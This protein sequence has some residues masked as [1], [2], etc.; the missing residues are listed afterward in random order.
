ML[1]KSFILIFLMVLGISAKVSW[2]GNDD[3]TY[4]LGLRYPKSYDAKIDQN[5]PDIHF[6]EYKVRLSFPSKEVVQFYDDKLKAIGWVP[7]VEPNYPKFCDRT[8]DHFIDGT[9]K[10]TPIVHQLCAQWVTKD[11]NRMVGLVIR[12]HSTYSTDKDKMHAKEPNNNIQEVTLQVMPF[13]ILPPPIP[14]K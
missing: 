4:I 8:W 9:I 13:Y 10:D 1:K 2:S 5:G 6:V 7:F 11:H 3:E 14:G 12:Y